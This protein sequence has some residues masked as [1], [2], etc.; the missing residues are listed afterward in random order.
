MR[1]GA[2]TAA[3]P[4][5][6]RLRRADAVAE[7]LRAR[8]VSGALPTGTRLLQAEV[9][10]SLGV[11]TTPV[12]EA[13]VTLQRQ[14]LLSGDAHRGVIVFRPSIEDLRE[15]IA[16]RSALE[17]LATEQA[18]D[19]ITRTDLDALDALLATMA[20]AD[21]SDYARLN[22]EFHVRIYALVRWPRL[23]MIIE[24]L[25]DASTAYMNLVAAGTG[26]SADRHQ[27]HV[28]IVE[29]LRARAPAE[30]GA[31]MRAHLAHAGQ[32]LL[33]QMSDLTN[34][35]VEIAPD[36]L[37]HRAALPKAGDIRN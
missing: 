18:A 7:E 28:A 22:R 32:I 34:R 26:F 5:A 8:I 23:V 11:S 25:R 14:G 6:R 1:L 12:R 35:A 17:V 13:F 36:S 19:H 33:A 10:K 29:A 20:S 27:E 16:M 21:A 24:Q 2:L 37:Q 30:A 4:K 3:V 31:A 15:N 9:A